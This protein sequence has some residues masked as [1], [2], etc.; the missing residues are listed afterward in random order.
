MPDITLNK[1]PSPGQEQ[2]I[3]PY[4]P[5]RIHHHPK[6]FRIIVACPGGIASLT[7]L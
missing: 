5:E 4:C 3:A 6:A 2:Q 1:M 7:V